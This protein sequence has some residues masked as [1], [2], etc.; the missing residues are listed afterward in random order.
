MVTVGWHEPPVAT[1][2]APRSEPW[3]PQLPLT[4]SHEWTEVVAHGVAQ[5]MSVKNSSFVPESQT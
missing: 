4:A 3:L 1:G 5:P 2:T